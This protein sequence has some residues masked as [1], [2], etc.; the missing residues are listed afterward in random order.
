MGFL[1]DNVNLMQMFDEYALDARAIDAEGLDARDVYG[2]YMDIGERDLF[3]DD[4]EDFFAREY[5]DQD[6]SERDGL[7]DLLDYVTREEDE[8]AL[9]ARY[10]FDE[11]E[12][13]QYNDD[14]VD[15]MRR[16]YDFDDVEVSFNFVNCSIKRR[17]LNR[18]FFLAR[19][20]RAFS[21]SNWNCGTTTQWLISA[22]RYVLLNICQKYSLLFHYMRTITVDV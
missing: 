17:V 2:T 8:S 20:Q 16:A 15:F 7:Q 18:G 13:R 6:L 12:E 21:L 22:D 3:D 11:L 19:S 10:D 4:L 5:F 14:E 1:T 9:Q